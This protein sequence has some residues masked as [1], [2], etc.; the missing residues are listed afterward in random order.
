[1]AEKTFNRKTKVWTSNCDVCDRRFQSKRRHTSTCS[2]KCRKEKSRALQAQP[3]RISDESVESSAAAAERK[4]N[5]RR[6]RG[7]KV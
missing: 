4:T 7:G 5:K 6:A 1:M 2:L 3:S